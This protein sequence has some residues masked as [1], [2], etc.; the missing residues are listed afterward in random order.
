VQ[1]LQGLSG[2]VTQIIDL[3]VSIDVEAI[4]RGSPTQ[5]AAWIALRE[6]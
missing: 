4:G 5:D 6:E 1:A 3:Q 2:T